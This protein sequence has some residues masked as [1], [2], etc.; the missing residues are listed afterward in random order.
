MLAT[1]IE[2]MSPMTTDAHP[3]SVTGV[4]PSILVVD[5]TSVSRLLIGGLITRE[6]GRSVITAENGRRALEILE[7]GEIA[8]VVT[9]LQMPELNGLQLVETIR[10]RFPSIPVI[11]M[12]AYGSG[13]SP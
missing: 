12:T 9:D 5:D 11:L 8:A 2:T 4:G 3:T 1:G 10:D 13:W 6:T 7:R